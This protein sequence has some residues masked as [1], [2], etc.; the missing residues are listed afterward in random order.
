LKLD[1][2]KVKIILKRYVGGEKNIQLLSI[3]Y[4]VSD[5][6]MR[7]VVTRRSWKHVVLD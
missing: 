6:A 2:E 1:T 3:E 4:G 5:E 7:N